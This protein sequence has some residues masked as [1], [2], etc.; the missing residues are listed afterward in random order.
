VNADGRIP[1]AVLDSAVRRR[2]WRRWELDLVRGGVTPMTA[3]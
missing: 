1:A 3:P 2:E